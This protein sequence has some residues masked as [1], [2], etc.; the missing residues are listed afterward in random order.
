MSGNQI[1][2]D[3]ESLHI[4]PIGRIEDDDRR[5]HCCLRINHM[6]SHEFV[7][8][9]LKSMGKISYGNY[10]PTV[11]D[12][13]LAIVTLNKDIENLVEKFSVKFGVSAEVLVTEDSLKLSKY[14]ILTKI[15][16]INGVITD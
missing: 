5:S 12:L 7:L 16:K 13:S 3:K 4:C 2:Y 6:G 10:L 11:N 8:E 1:D 9:P 15:V 14:N